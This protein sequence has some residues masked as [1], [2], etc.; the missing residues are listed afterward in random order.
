MRRL[1]VDPESRRWKR[2]DAIRD[3]GLALQKESLM[4]NE[5]VESMSENFRQATFAMV[6]GRIDQW[7]EERRISGVSPNATT[8]IQEEYRSGFK[9]RLLA[10]NSEATTSS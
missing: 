6:G 9:C 8:T 2:T 1:L 5:Y 4:F 10:M 7:R 3:V